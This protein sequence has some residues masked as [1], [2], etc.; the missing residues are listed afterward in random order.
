MGATMIVVFYPKSKSSE[1][2]GRS[3]FVVRAWIGRCDV[4]AWEDQLEFGKDGLFGGSPD[5]FGVERS[6]DEVEQRRNGSDL[7][8]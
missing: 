4:A 5:K 7:I 2:I 1:G 3:C 8:P 6:I